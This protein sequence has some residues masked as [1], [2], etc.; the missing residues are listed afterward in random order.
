MCFTA[1]QAAGAV[2]DISFDQNVKSRLAA[3]VW[4]QEATG[5]RTTPPEQRSKKT[6]VESIYEWF[7]RVEK[8][9]ANGCEDA[10]NEE[11]DVGMESH[12]DAADS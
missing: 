11:R 6:L 3:A 2:A 4:S 10:R 12:E 1:T 7:G 9:D 8:K 5:S